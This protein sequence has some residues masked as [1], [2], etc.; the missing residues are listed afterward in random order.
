MAGQI[1]KALNEII[2]QRSKGS[3]TLATTTKTK[4]M[5]K[6]VNPDDFTESSP[7]DQAV[8]EKVHLIAVELGIT[9]SI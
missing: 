5:L 2:F 4:L 7:D 6:G 3:Q 9:L 1:K 8:L